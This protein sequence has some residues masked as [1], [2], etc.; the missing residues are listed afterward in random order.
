M[1]P[2]N[3]VSEGLKRRIGVA[4][5]LAIVAAGTLL[6]A[7]TPALAS[8]AAPCPNEA[9]RA[10]SNV[11]PATGQP[12]DMS[13]PD[14]RAYEMVTPLAKEAHSV[15]LV[16]GLDP[17]GEGVV[18]YTLAAGD[19]DSEG[20]IQTSAWGNTFASGRGASGWLA[21]STVPPQGLIEKS[22]SNVGEA[23]DYSVDMSRSATCGS[24]AAS[25]GSSSSSGVVCALRLPDGT[26]L[27]SPVYSTL[28]GV[29]FGVPP[30]YLGASADLSR[31]FFTM[32]SANPSARLLAQDTSTNGSSIYEV[33][34]LESGE[35]VLS[36]VSVGNDGSPIGTG[37]GSGGYQSISDD[38]RTVYF[39]ATPTGASGAHVYARVDGSSTVEVSA[40]ECTICATTFTGASFVGASA[41]GSRVFMQTTS[42]LTASD[43]DATADLYMYDFNAQLGHRLVQVSAGDGSD[44]NAGNGAQVQGLVQLSAD[45]SHVFFVALGVLTTKENINGQ[46][47]VSGSPNLYVYERDATY[48]NGRTQFIATLPAGD[49]KVW[50]EGDGLRHSQ[51]T[52][53]GR[54][55]IF[56]TTAKLITSGPEADTDEAV[57]IYRYDSETGEL[58]RISVGEP[59]FPTSNN[60]NTP[61]GTASITPLNYN[62]SGS[63]ASVNMMGR[64]I[65]GDGSYVLFNTAEKLQEDDVDGSLDYYLWHN[66]EV[67]MI[68]DGQETLSNIVGASL[69]ES[70]D[71]VYFQTHTALVAQD[72]DTLGDVYDA[73][74]DGGY[75]APTPA[76]ECAGEGCQ[77]TP[78]ATPSFGSPA[79]SLTQ[80]G[81]GNIPTPPVSTTTTATPKVKS[82]TRSQ[83][84]INALKTC[85]KDKGGKKKVACEKAARKRYRSAAKK[86][87]K[88]KK[89]R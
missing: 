3:G 19:A 25:S 81:G 44:V 52:A 13:L 12:Y 11:D 18:G 29:T 30:L 2:H 41:D 37:A 1:R 23:A 86:K 20:F 40:P 72:R 28:N 79:G 33:S 55:L 54:Y 85:R 10:E 89:K 21:S 75:P 88:A 50:T 15:N 14:C 60:G 48:P 74:I 7:A 78:G 42:A 4:V 49:T 24:V 68:S 45:G 6:P 22:T 71:D 82:L 43:T 64:A 70:G 38:G 26:W 17:A 9:V 65:S 87:A 51:T 8:E 67:S 53:D 63:N 56:E 32:G 61:G 76:A 47:A 57:D 46:S 66:G 35:P 31:L 39:T 83:K 69:S 36:L 73:R 84:L 59:D 80:I 58:T 34:G 27:A 77:G 16:P 62:Y 5:S